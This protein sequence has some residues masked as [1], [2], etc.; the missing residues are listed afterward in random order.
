MAKEEGKEK[1]EETERKDKKRRTSKARKNESEI[2]KKEQ[3]KNKKNRRLHDLVLSRSDSYDEMLLGKCSLRSVAK[4]YT[5]S[6]KNLIG[7]GTF[8]NVHL[9]CSWCRD[10]EGRA[11]EQSR[12]WRCL[13]EWLE[14]GMGNEALLF[15]RWIWSGWWM[16]C[17]G[18][19]HQGIQK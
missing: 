9:S 19:A 1:T 13:V 10:G 2:K 14:D 5:W 3:K 16:I 8:A 6:E 12:V 11:W 18:C 17:G 4:D 7:R 15:L